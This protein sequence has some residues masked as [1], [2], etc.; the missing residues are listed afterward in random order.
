MSRRCR[1]FNESL[2]FC[3]MRLGFPFIAPRTLRAVGSPFGRLGC[4]LSVGTPDSE[5]CSISFLIWWTDHCQPLAPWHTR[6]SGAACWPLAEPR[7]A[8][9]SHGRPLAGRVICTPNSPVNYSRD[10]LAFSWELHVHRRYQP[11]TG[12]SGAPQASVSLAGLSQTSPI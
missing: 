6:Q 8:R 10:T 2:V 7:G 9:W 5:Q 11:S 4:L 3:T 12:Q 1:M